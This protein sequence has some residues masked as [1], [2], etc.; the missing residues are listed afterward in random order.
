MMIP[1]GIIAQFAPKSQNFQK[2]GLRCFWLNFY[3]IKQ[4]INFFKILSLL[5]T[6]RVNKVFTEYHWLRR[7]G[8]IGMGQ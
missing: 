2:I 8:R 1:Y 7:I 4:K 3:N 6:Y 5:M